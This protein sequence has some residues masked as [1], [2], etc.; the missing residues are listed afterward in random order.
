MCWNRPFQPPLYFRAAR[1]FEIRPYTMVM[2]E[3]LLQQQLS[4]YPK[5]TAGDS[6]L[7][8][9]AYA[10]CA[11]RRRGCRCARE[12]MAD[13]KSPVARRARRTYASTI[14]TGFEVQK[15]LSQRRTGVVNRIKNSTRHDFKQTTNGTPCRSLL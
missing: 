6:L 15:Y 14:S 7:L 10:Y 11:R 1:K 12:E 2:E 8:E 5:A 9:T 3:C 13:R 4:I